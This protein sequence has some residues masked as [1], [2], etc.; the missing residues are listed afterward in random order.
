MA[1][2]ELG[3]AEPQPLGRAGREVLHEDVGPVQ[4]RGQ[5]RLAVGAFHVEL[6]RFL[7][8]VQP[9]EVARLAEHGPVVAAGEVAGARPLDL[10]D[11]GAEVGELP[12][13]ERDGDRLLQRHDQET[14]EWQYVRRQ[15]PARVSG[16]G[17]DPAGWR[18]TNWR[19]MTLR[20]ISLVP[21]PTI[22]SGA[23]R[24]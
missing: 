9:H 19:A 2:A 7:A 17:H 20:W 23:S 21:S 15:G 14:V 8:P 6:D 12:R 10:D 3:G 4:Q 1:G 24:K 16:A 13:G 22:I 18:W 5:R 11:P